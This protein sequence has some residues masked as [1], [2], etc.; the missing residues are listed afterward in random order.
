MLPVG[1]ASVVWMI[2][3]FGE[4]IDEAPYLLEHLVDGFAEEAASVVRME[5][6]VPMAVVSGD[7][8]ILCAPTRQFVGER[9]SHTSNWPC[10]CDEVWVSLSRACPPAAHG[11][12][13]AVLQAPA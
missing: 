12:H 3:E 5:V 1:Q 13:Q 9:G 11:H 2:G 6:R 8:L 10:W 7:L 4:L